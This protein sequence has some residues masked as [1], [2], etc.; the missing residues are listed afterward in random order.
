MDVLVRKLYLAKVDRHIDK[1]LIKVLIS[2]RRVG[3]SYFVKTII[4]HITR[5]IPRANIIFIDKEL[6]DYDNISTYH[7]LIEFVEKELKTGIKNFLILD[8]IQEITNFQKALDQ[9]K[10]PVDLYFYE[11]IMAA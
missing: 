2:Q 1:N 5:K 8:E 4:N 7:E 3:K 10:F 11:Q 6:Y 9:F